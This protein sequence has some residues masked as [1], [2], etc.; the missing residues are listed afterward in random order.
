MVAVSAA[1][2][3]AAQPTVSEPVQTRQEIG[4]LLEQLDSDQYDVRQRA[5]HRL[6]ELTTRKNSAELVAVELQ[7]ALVRADLSLEVRKRL[8]ALSRQLPRVAPEPV[9]E[10]SQA[11][12]ERLIA[13]LEHDSYSERLG[14][15]QRLEWLLGN[16]RL[17][18]PI[19]LRL[20]QQIL[21]GRL[22]VDARRWLEP[23]DE[24]ARAVW[25]AS[26]PKNWDLPAVADQ[27]IDQWISELAKHETPER[28]PAREARRIAQRELRDLLARDELVPKVKA[29]LAAKLAEAGLAKE[30]ATRLQELLELTRP[31]MVAEYWMGR[32]HKGSQHLI[33]GTPSWGQGAV[34]PS[35]F[36]R[37][38]DQTAHC[39]SGQNLSPG[40]YPV[41]VAVPHPRMEG[42]AFFHLVNLPTPR[43]R[44]S[45]QYVRQQPDPV[46]LAQISRRTVDRFLQRKTHL[47]ESEL[48]LLPLLD[49]EVMS[50][51]AARMLM[52][53][54]DESLPPE[55]ADRLGGRSSHHG[56]LCA[57]LAMEGTQAAI[58]TLLEA[59][60][61]H[62]VLP[63]TSKSPYGMD[64][65]A[66]LAI[67]ARD[68]WAE[69]EPW[70]LGLVERKDPLVQG[71]QNPPQLGATAAA[72]LLEQHEQ[73]AAL[74]GL[75][76]TGERTLES[77][78][79]RG[80]RFTSDDSPNLVRQW[81]AKQ[82][83]PPVAHVS[84]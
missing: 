32:D 35:H 16:P 53:L 15:T 68:P 50:A 82:N 13:Q 74:F 73:N 56:L 54:A 33:V 78:G 55:G 37:I 72:I 46:R 81:W 77:L 11:E 63:P 57:A 27:Q 51:F 48:V 38:D 24:K 80:C 60:Q 31:A 26:D 25:L 14:A 23:M 18:S 45:Y 39:V 22:S 64:W 4:Q 29:A 62:R 9:Q 6:D 40:D 30:G 65:L 36:D 49:R 79:I 17:A 41:G 20:K 69:A 28:A 7:R 67:A 47:T 58:P 43:R 3:L 59:I 10:A 76:P 44:M 71:M 84:P 52:S 75:E 12:V 42:A 5:S 70:L 8:G 1:C 19:M 66:A 61:A 34:R 21:S 83:H 2:V